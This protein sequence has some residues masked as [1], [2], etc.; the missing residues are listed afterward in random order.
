MKINFEW[1]NIVNNSLTRAAAGVQGEGNGSF[2]FVAMNK[3]EEGF[4]VSDWESMTARMEQ[5]IQAKEYVAIQRDKMTIMSNTMSPEDF[6]KMKEDGYQINSMEPDEIVTIL[7]NIKTELAKGGTHVAGYTDSVSM[8]T[9]T[10]ILGNRGY[11]QAVIKELKRAD[12]PVCE[13]NIIKI[14]EAVDQALGLT[15]PGEG[16]KAFLVAGRMEP[17]ISNLYKAEHSSTGTGKSGTYSGYASG[18]YSKYGVDNSTVR[19]MTLSYEELGKIEK[20]IKER[21]EALGVEANKDTVEK[22]KWLLEK[23]LPVTAE[24][25]NLLQDLES[26]EFPLDIEKLIRQSA[27]AIAEGKSPF[28]INL[29]ASGESIYEKAADIKDRFFKLPLEAADYAVSIRGSITLIHMEEYGGSSATPAKNLQARKVLEEV[30]LKM[31]V[32]ANVKLLR[33]GYAIDTSPM[34]DL[35][36]QLDQVISHTE[37][38][39]FG[40]NNA[41]EK[42]GLFKEALGRIRELP[43]LPLAT[44]GRFNSYHEIT[45]QKFVEEGRVIKQQYEAAR[46]SYEV[47]MTAPRPDLGDSIKKAFRNVDDILEDMGLEITEANQRAVRIMGYNQITISEENL[48]R[49]KEA[50]NKV[51]SVIEKMKPARTLE[52]IREGMNPLEMT[53]DEIEEYLISKENE[54][55]ESTEKYSE[56]LYRLERKNQISDTERKAYIGIYRMIR[57]IEKSDGAVIGSLMAQDAGLSFSNLLSAVRSNK[58]KGTDLRIDD[59]FGAIEKVVEKGISI[60]EQIKA[61]E[62]IERDSELTKELQ[63]QQLKDIREIVKASGKEKEY[64][65]SYHQPVT[66]DNLAAAGSLTKKRGQAFSKV[67]SLEAEENMSTEEIEESILDHAREFIN[68]LEKN[69]IRNKNYDKIIEK[70]KQVLEDGLEKIDPNHLNLK[71]L[72]SVYKQLSIAHSLS[73]EENYEIPVKIGVEY[74]SINLKVVHKAEESGNVK[75]TLDTKA[76]GRVEARFVL[77]EAVLEGSVLT[78][79]MDNKNTLEK[80]ADELKKAIEEALEETRVEVKALYFGTNAAMDINTPEKNEGMSNNDISLLYKVAKGFIRYIIRT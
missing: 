27:I 12:V 5:P 45:I 71:E 51:K 74:T 44:V 38:S 73:R 7:D 36:R 75:I 11:A 50:D 65:Q 64:L 8:D 62:S 46:D 40:K 13:E 79:H 16:T 15:N 55:L 34:E 80:R 72:Q 9:V 43:T 10:K 6:A 31:T 42:A 26:I 59:S 66:I 25:L 67:F 35:I 33:S 58:A 2:A 54:F 77:R 4:Q 30:R 68:T 18:G 60:S 21:A 20:Q 56:F 49:I 52:M 57:Q 28:D 61:M 23:G 24:N 41:T 70:S 69:E 14:G 22:G 3:S 48:D 53:M 19:K 32:E 17:T 63:E 78:D 29:N 37:E 47:M 76:L 39:L 1:K